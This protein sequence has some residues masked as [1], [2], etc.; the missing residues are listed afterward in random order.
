[1]FAPPDVGDKNIANRKPSSAI[2]RVAVE[3]M[4]LVAEE[5]CVPAVTAF[6][7]YNLL[8]RQVVGT[9]EDKNRAV[10]RRMAVPEWPFDVGFCC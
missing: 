10:R 8:D 9:A 5:D 2:R 3:I 6:D 1:M 4:E 7:R